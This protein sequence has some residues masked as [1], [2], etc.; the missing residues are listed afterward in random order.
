M[1][2][3]HLEE[4]L[5]FR[6][7]AQELGRKRDPRGRKLRSMVLAKERRIGREIAIRLSGAKEPKLRVTLG[8]IYRHFPELRPA[9]VDDLVVLARQL[10]ERGDARTRS[11]V[12]QILAEGVEPRL[13][14]VEKAVGI[15]T[16]SLEEVRDCFSQ[17]LTGTSQNG[18]A[19]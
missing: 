1:R 15:M 3:P 5:S 7:A 8:A 13:S 11:L 12:Q 17:E 9:R 18:P 10:A 4:E 6:E 16:R 14:S 2:R 19:T